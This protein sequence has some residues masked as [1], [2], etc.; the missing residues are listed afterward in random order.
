MALM[1]N[2]DE[3]AE[4][5]AQKGES[6]SR[7]SKIRDAVTKGQTAAR[8]DAQQA[9][10]LLAAALASEAAYSGKIGRIDDAR[11]K[12][13]TQE[14][15]ERAE[16]SGRANRVTG[17]TL[18]LGME[19]G[20]VTRMARGSMEPDWDDNPEH[21]D[22][23]AEVRADLRDSG[24]DPMDTGTEEEATFGHFLVHAFADDKDHG[25]R[26]PAQLEAEHDMVV[27]AMQEHGVDHHSPLDVASPL[28]LTPAASDG[29][30]EPDNPFEFDDPW[31]L[32]GGA[33]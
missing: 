4:E 26:T 17:H 10:S 12:S 20:T 15:A 6:K 14:M 18:D 30:I 5:R 29:E 27:E 9:N 33:D 16:R 7:L 13:R 1:P 25:G 23:P 22:T 28:A 3:T 21:L 19:D 2:T 11:R 32:S 8:Q 24:L 31:G